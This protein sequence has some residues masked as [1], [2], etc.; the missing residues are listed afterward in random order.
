MKSNA[1]M[2]IVGLSLIAVAMLARCGGGPSRPPLLAIT[3]AAVPN[4]ML[5]E[6]YSQVIQA[7]GGVAPFTW[8][9]SAGALPHSV[10]LGQSS[11]NA[12]MISGTPDT[13]AQRV[14]FTI[15]VTDSS[16]Q[17]AAQPYTVSVLAVPDTLTLAPA[18]LGFAPQLTGTPSAAQS[19]TITNAGTSSVFIN[20]IAVTGTNA[21]DFSES[22]TCGTSLAAGATCAVNVTLTASQPG[23]RSAAVTITDDTMG[24]PHSVSLSGVG[25]TS[26]PNATWS[27]TSLTFP[28]QYVG[29]TSS[30]Q[31]LT[32]TNYGTTTLSISSITVTASFGETDTCIGSSLASGANCTVNVT[33]T[34]SSLTSL[35]GTLSVTDS[36]PSSPQALPLAGTTVQAV[37][38]GYCDASVRQ[39]DLTFKCE[40]NQ[41]AQCPVGQ[42]AITPTVGALDCG[43][44]T[45]SV[46]FDDSRTCQVDST[47]GVCLTKYVYG[48]ASDKVTDKSLR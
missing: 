27:A 47:N 23:P 42:P 41:D 16:A 38:T 11:S 29:T 33:F 45:V 8:T 25:L 19:T 21:A 28:Q 44:S 13:A 1:R 15:T 3:T 14:A 22:N 2:M 35:S 30:A 12:V 18:T 31:S 7:S 17:S 36:A 48:S 39:K 34:P 24:S 46:S 5:N 9:V 6:A 40:I 20:N 4:G 26:G 43:V 10:A 32:L 37:L